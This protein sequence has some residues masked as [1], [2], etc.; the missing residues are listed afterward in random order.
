MSSLSDLMLARDATVSAIVSALRP[1]FPRGWFGKL[2]IT[3]EDGQVR[4]DN[5]AVELRSQ[6]R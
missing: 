4:R 2:V 3:V 5:I 1:V 6:Q